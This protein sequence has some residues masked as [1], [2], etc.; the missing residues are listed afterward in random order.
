MVKVSKLLYLL[1]GTISASQSAVHVSLHSGIFSQDG[2]SSLDQKEDLSHSFN[3]FSSFIVE[4][5]SNL[6]SHL[7]L[8]EKYWIIYRNDDHNIPTTYDS[9]NQ[10]GQFGLNELDGTVNEDSIQQ[11]IESISGGFEVYREIVA[12]HFPENKGFLL[13]AFKKVKINSNIKTNQIT[14]Y[15]VALTNKYYPKFKVNILRGSGPS[16]DG[17]S[18]ET[19]RWGYFV[20]PATLKTYL[21]ELAFSGLYDLPAALDEAYSAAE[22]DAPRG[23][24]LKMLFGGS[25]GYS[26]T[27]MENN[28]K[29]GLYTGVDL[30]FD[31][32]PNRTNISKNSIGIKQNNIGITPFIGIAAKDSWMIY[33]IAGPKLSFKNL[34]FQNTIIKKTKVEFEVGAGTDYMLT[35][36]FA[37]GF[38]YLKTLKSNVK[39]KHNYI[40]YNLRTSSS[41]F[42]VSLSYIF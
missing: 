42:I 23:S 39:F 41:K 5:S 31:T 20:D 3:A 22:N 32:C 17:S 2:K 7:K 37:V 21:S 12:K 13:S 1:G 29:F 33:A 6:L 11:S 26:H 40:N 4:E 14:F 25:V 30:F 18:P 35:D 36:H 27:F 28:K 24:K 16:G 15:N 9:Q 19:I 34:S 38:R 10:R 8:M